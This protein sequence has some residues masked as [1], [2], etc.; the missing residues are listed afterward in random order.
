MCIIFIYNN[1]NNKIHR[2]MY[3]K[4]TKYCQPVMTTELFFS[5][6][7]P[8]DQSNAI[9]ISVFFWKGGGGGGGVMQPHNSVLYH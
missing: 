6:G 8:I 4:E 3:T 9:S 5:A 7:L 1:N 2:M